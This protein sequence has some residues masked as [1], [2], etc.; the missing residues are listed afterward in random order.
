MTLGGEAHP[1]EL[2]IA[3]SDPGSFWEMQRWYQD[4][5]SVSQ[6]F[7]RE[8]FTELGQSWALQ[9]AGEAADH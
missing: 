9:A 5:W 1:T 8:L 2:N 6:D 4:L 3:L 7:H